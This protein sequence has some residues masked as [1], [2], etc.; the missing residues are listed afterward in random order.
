W[1]SARQATASRWRYKSRWPCWASSAR[2]SAKSRACW[3]KWPAA[4]MRPTSSR[5]PRCKAPRRIASSWP[6]P[7]NRTAPRTN[8]WSR[9]CGRCTASWGLAEIRIRARNSNQIRIQNWNDRSDLWFALRVMPSSRLDLFVASWFAPRH[10]ATSPLLPEV[11]A[12][13]A[14][15]YAAGY[16]NPASQHRAGR[17]ARQALEDAREGIAAMLGAEL[18]SAA[19]DAL[20]LTSGGTEANNLAL[21]GLVGE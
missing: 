2:A 18:T 12:A 20:I 6:C 14:A 4:W 9:P 21:F 3:P 10:N 1:P 15:C 16:A 8:R 7:I 19:P 11:A 13:M 5:W 17:R